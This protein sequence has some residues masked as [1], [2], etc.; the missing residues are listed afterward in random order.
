MHDGEPVT[1]SGGTA[2]TLHQTILR[3]IEGKIVSGEWPPGHRLP[4]E[5]N[6]AEQYG[7]SRMTVNKVMTQ[8]AKAGL[9]ERHRKAGSFVTTP[10]AQSAVLEIHDVEKEVRSLG[11]PYAFSLQ[12]QSL[13]KATADDQRQMEVSRGISVRRIVAVHMAGG[14]P[15]CV[16][17]RL[18]NASVVGEAADVDFQDT[19]PGPWLIAKVPWTTAEHRI[20]AVSASPTTAK[21]LDKPQGTSC[22]VIERRTWSTT[23]AVTFVR[24][25][26]PGERHT[27]VARF[28]PA[29]SSEGIIAR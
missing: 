11:L 29:Q 4:F 26:Y 14:K 21:L 7:C 8:L 2:T 22:L 16:E 17:E 25:T 9:I 5:V 10:R 18:I 1:R 15:F 6:L 23:G 12:L 19:P 20:S 24:F 27:L 13:G 3:E 28:T